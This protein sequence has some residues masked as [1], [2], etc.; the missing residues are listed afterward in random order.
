[1][2]SRKKKARKERINSEKA[3]TT[4]T[5]DKA[6]KDY[7]NEEKDIAIALDVMRTSQFVQRY[8]IEPPNRQLRYS[9][10]R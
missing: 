4:I 10:H 6:V 2:R 7:F 5:L 9:L 1:M 8:R 3:N